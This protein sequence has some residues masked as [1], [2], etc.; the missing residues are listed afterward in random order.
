MVV[1]LTMAL[2]VV[3][4][5]A[6]PFRPALALVSQEELLCFQLKLIDLLTDRFEALLRVVVAEGCHGWLGVV[7]GAGTNERQIAGSGDLRMYIGMGGWM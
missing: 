4:A 1:L 3:V 7:G 2:V 6:A 5:F